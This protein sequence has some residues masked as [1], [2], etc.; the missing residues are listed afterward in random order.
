LI[1]D[2]RERKMGIGKGIEQKEIEMR[3]EEQKKM[4]D[5]YPERI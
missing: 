1:E 2:G 3:E 4:G 5:K